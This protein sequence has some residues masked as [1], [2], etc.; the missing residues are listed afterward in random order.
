MVTPNYCSTS[1]RSLL[2]FIRLCLFSCMT[3]DLLTPCTLQLES[4]GWRSGVRIAVY[5]IGYSSYAS[6]NVHSS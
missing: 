1:A 5:E 4:N 2:I 3:Y 6:S